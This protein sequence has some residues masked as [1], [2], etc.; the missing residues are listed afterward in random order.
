MACI[1]HVKATTVPFLGICGGR[2]LFTKSELIFGF[3]KDL[4]DG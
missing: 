3:V 2:Q 4:Y 1:N